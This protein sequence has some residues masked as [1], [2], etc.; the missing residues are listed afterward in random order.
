MKRRQFLQAAGWGSL[1][2][3]ATTAIPTLAQ[4]QSGT[5]QIQFFGHSCFRFTGGGLPAIVVN[6]FRPGGCTAGLPMPRQSAGIVLLS[7][8]LLDEGYAEAITGNPRILFEAGVYR[9]GALQIQGVSLPHDRLGGRRFGRNV[10]WGWSQAGLSILN[11]GGAA[12]PLTVENQIL[13][14]SPDIL[15][16]PVGGSAKSFNAEEA[17]AAIDLL[18]P[19]LIIPTMYRTSA[20]SKEACDLGGLQPFLELMSGTPVQRPGRT[21]NLQRSSLPASGSRIIVM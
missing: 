2:A 1:G 9:I 16:V 4:A 13:L 3:I 19:R 18:K 11:L 7:S 12:A 6:P 10:A 8:R 14:G 5:L 21:V 15:L 20:A 17:K